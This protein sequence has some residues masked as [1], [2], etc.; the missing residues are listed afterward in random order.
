MF[1][2]TKTHMLLFQGIFENWA[3][4]N[5]LEDLNAPLSDM[6][7]NYT[8]YAI[9]SLFFLQSRTD[10][11]FSEYLFTKFELYKTR[12]HT[13]KHYLSI[14]TNTIS[15]ILYINHVV[16]LLRLRIHFVTIIFRT[17]EEDPSKLLE[18]LTH[19]E[20]YFLRYDQLSSQDFS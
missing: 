11:Y 1:G 13:A 3:S 4:L 17:H 7:Y 5:K 6:E 16:P 10:F 20:L 2:I 12:S 19:P 9:Q 18:F 14:L 15:Y 8:I